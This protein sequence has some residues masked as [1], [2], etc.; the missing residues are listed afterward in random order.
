M[1]KR[2]KEFKDC[3]F[4]GGFSANWRSRGQEGKLFKD[5]RILWH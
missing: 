1:L 2:F 3:N 5:T 4:G